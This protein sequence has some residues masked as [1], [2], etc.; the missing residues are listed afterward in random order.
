MDKLDRSGATETNGKID[1]HREIL[2]IY[3]IYL[4]LDKYIHI[5]LCLSYDSIHL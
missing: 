5:F 2:Y 3:I 4:Y 1:K